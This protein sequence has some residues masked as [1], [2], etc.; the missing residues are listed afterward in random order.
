MESSTLYHITNASVSPELL[1]RE[2]ENIQ[3]F[4]KK[5]E[6]YVSPVATIHFFTVSTSVFDLVIETKDI[7]EI[8]RVRAA[9]KSR[10]RFSS[11]FIIQ[12]LANVLN[13]YAL[14]YN[15]RYKRTGALFQKNFKYGQISEDQ[16]SDMLA[17]LL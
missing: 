4:R 12:Q 11:G 1:F 3:F 14:H 8:C 16:F 9:L 15:K 17:V 7:H 10:R 13:S 2:E 5:L 6:Q